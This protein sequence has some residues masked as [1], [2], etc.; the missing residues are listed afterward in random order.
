MF[1]GSLLIGTFVACSASDGNGRSGTGGTGNTAAVDGGSDA[2]GTGGSA[3]GSGGSAGTGGDSGGLSGCALNG[4]IEGQ[5]CVAGACCEETRACGDVC[6]GTGELCS[7]ATCVVP[8]IDCSNSTQCP[9]GQYCETSLGQPSTGACTAPNGKCLPKPPECAPGSPPAGC[10]EKCEHVPTQAFDPVLK[11]KWPSDVESP[12]APYQNDIMMTPIVVQLDDDN[13]DG[14]ITATDVPDIL[15][16]TFANGGWPGAGVLH[17]LAIKN[18]VLTELWNVAGVWPPSALA[19]GNLDGLN[20]NEI[21]ACGPGGTTVKAF[22]N[23]GTPLWTAT[24]SCYTPAL[25]DLDGDGKP[26]VVVEGGIIDGASGGVTHTFSPAPQGFATVADIT[27]DGKPEI[28]FGNRAYDTNGSVIADASGQISFVSYAWPSV[29]DF[30]LDGKPEVAVTLFNANSFAL[31]RYDA[32]QPNNVQVL[33]APFQAHVNPGGGWGWS[34]G[35]GPITVGDFD[36]DGTPDAG[37]VGFRGYVVLDG[38]KL[39]NAGVG[40]T[41]SELELWSKP[42]DEDN[43]STGSAVFDFDGDGKVEVLYDDTQRVHIYDGATGADKATPIC[44]TTGSQFEY[45]VVADVDND[46]QA[47]L[48]LVANGFSNKP[49]QNP[50]YDCDGSVQSGLRVFGSASKSWVQTR[51]IW[52]QHTY[53]VTN[54]LDDGSIPANE[55][56]NWTVSGLNNFRQNKQVGGEFGAPDAVV[57]L[58]P[59]CGTPYGIRV[60][61]RNMGSAPIPAG[62]I[63]NVY[64]TE[65]KKLLGSVTTTY[66]LFPLQGETLFL[67]VPPPDDEDLMSGAAH[68][69]AVVDEAPKQLVECRPDNNESPS[70][71]VACGTPR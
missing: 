69:Y 30:D 13:C 1:V 68:A 6:C 51:P 58:L 66:S 26:E 4:C 65:D 57:S 63:A 19:G 32:T 59:S 7:F 34:Y 23:T 31:W 70:T 46:G 50:S 2:A 14:A 11:Y 33:R 56:D 5:I 17:A 40:S 48:I 62:I 36:G 8:G 53:H 44:N 61:V 18:G 29:A 25:A 27:G 20:G 39:M 54:V 21:V 16:T 24:L 47:D 43:G 52:N 38:K 35:M 10:V 49:G 42:T 12:T 45:P 60:E 67:A 41:L 3:G 55:T 9:D 22:S 28:V 64:R 15:A 37:Y 71:L